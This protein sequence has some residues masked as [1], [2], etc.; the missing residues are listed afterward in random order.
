MNETIVGLALIIALACL[1]LIY[2]FFMFF[3]MA[4]RIMLWN[5]TSQTPPIAG[6]VWNQQGGRLYVIHVTADGQTVRLRSYGHKEKT[7][8][9]ESLAAWKERIKLKHLYLMSKETAKFVKLLEKESN[10]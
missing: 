4:W 5:R 2:G 3:G 1:G 8:W 7:E 6:Q 10:G 9:D